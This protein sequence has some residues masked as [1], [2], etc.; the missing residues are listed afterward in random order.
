MAAGD[1]RPKYKFLAG[2]GDTNHEVRLNQAAEEGYR[3]ALIV[4]D[5]TVPGSSRGI[6]VLMEKR[7]EQAL[8]A[9][10]GAV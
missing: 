9:V 6:L 10:L 7:E 3:A 4:C 1:Q 8:G 2:S 5:V